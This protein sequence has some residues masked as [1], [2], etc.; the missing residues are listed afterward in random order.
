MMRAEKRLSVKKMTIVGVLGGISIVLGMTPLGFIPIGPT[1]ATIMHIPVII[2]AI[3][4]GPLVGGLIGLIFG[5]FSVFQAVTNPTPVSF[6]FINPIVSVVPRI[7]IGI[8]SY[9]VYRFVKELGE[10]KSFWILNAIWVLIV[11]YLSY[12]IYSNIVNFKSI[13]DILINIGLVIL[14]LL[15]GVYTNKRLK[16]RGIDIVMSAVAGTLTNTVGVLF[17][18]YVL[19][20]ERFVEALE[21]NVDT[22]RKVIVGIGI[23][24]GIPEIIIAVIVVT[25]VIIALRKRIK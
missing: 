11:G 16:N 24:N 1:R 15:L 12:G 5:M 14:T 8:V 7:L 21:Q 9:Y 23:A 4:E 22:V 10:E 19:Y 3:M 2:G 18:I 6:A 17:S 13:W 25:N 20:G